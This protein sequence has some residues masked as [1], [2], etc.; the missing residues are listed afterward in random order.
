MRIRVQSARL[1]KGRRRVC[2]ETV[3]GVIFYVAFGSRQVELSRKLVLTG[4]LGVVGRGTVG[5]SFFATLIAFYFFALS[6]RIQPFNTARLN[7]IKAFSELQI[8]VIMA[9]LDEGLLSLS[10]LILVFMGNSYGCN[11]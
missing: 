11:K 3:R 1:S 6:Y 8:F 7:R 9:G 5:Q 10:P 2:I 4:L